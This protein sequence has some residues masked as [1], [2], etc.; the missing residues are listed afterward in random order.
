MPATPSEFTKSLIAI[1]GVES[2]PKQPGRIA[3]FFGQRA[4]EYALHDIYDAVKLDYEITDRALMIHGTDRL[5]RVFVPS[6]QR[7]L[8]YQALRQL[9]VESYDMYSQLGDRGNQWVQVSLDGDREFRAYAAT[10]YL[11]D[12]APEEDGIV[13]ITVAELQLAMTGVP[14]KPNDSDR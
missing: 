14:V 2:L 10:R 1:G 7:D 11:L 4:V 3:R 13:G 5:A 12:D 9:G 8:A 6:D